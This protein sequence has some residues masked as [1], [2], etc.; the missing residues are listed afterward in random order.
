MA[1]VYVDGKTLL[2]VQEIPSKYGYVFSFFD[3]GITMSLVSS[4][5]V[6]RNRLKGMK[7]SYDLTT[8]GGNTTTQSTFLHDIPLI[9]SRG[10]VHV[11]QAFQMDEICGE[12]RP[13][14]VS[15]SVQLFEN[16]LIDD[17]RRKSGHIELLIGIRH[18]NIHPKAVAEVDSLVLYSSP[19]GTGKILAGSHPT[20]KSQDYV[21]ASASALAARIRN[22]RVMCQKRSRGR[23]LQFGGIWCKTYPEL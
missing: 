19:F 1:D 9:N 14:D 21:N 12:M 23:F 20:L 5:F 17:V 2:L 22:V 15:E 18:A 13:V 7:V 6:K 11:I 4:S 8:V 10:E 3:N 16:L